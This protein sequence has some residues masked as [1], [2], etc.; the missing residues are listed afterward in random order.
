MPG[1]LVTR[2]IDAPATRLQPPLVSGN[3]VFIERERITAWY[4]VSAGRLLGW[5]RVDLSTQVIDDIRQRIRQRTLLYAIFAILGGS[6]LVS[7]FLRL[8]MAALERARQFAF[9]LE[10]A[11]G[12]TLAPSSAPAEIGD[13]TA[14]L[15][16][17]SRNLYEQRQRLAALIGQLGERN[18]QLNAIFNLTQ[19]GFVSFDAG[20]C[21]SYVNPGFSRLTGLA[22]EATH[23]L[24]EAAFSAQLAARCADPA[25]CSPLA[26]L[27]TPMA[28]IHG[29]SELLLHADY[30]PAERREMLEIIHRQSGLMAAIINELIDLVL[31]EERRCKDFRLEAIDAGELVRKALASFRLPP[32]RQAPQIEAPTQPCRLRGDRKK[33]LQVLNNVLANAY[34]YSLAGGAVTVSLG[35]E[36]GQVALRISDCGIWMSTD[37]AARVFERFYRADASGKIP[38]T[39]LGMSIV[40]EIVELHGG[41][42]S[43]SS[44][45]GAGTTVSVFLLQA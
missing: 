12:R 39:G 42:V 7:L 17:A 35:I 27:R 36:S 16:H 13:L 8:P 24:D 10:T 23:G 45:P 21:V 6:L 1:E 29:F 30:P 32:G 31:I 14:A 33:L 3:L 41:S 40:R 26:D 43:L 20:R 18:E 15:N 25:R 44:A 19:D 28:S 2:I 34:K 9:E 37:E 4:P 11:G 22:P 5:I 38:G